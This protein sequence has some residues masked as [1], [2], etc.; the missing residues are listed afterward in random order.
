[1]CQAVDYEHA[2]QVQRS[3]VRVIYMECC[4][5]EHKIEFLEKILKL[6][7]VNEDTYNYMMTILFKHHALHAFDYNVKSEHTTNNVNE[8][9]NG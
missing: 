9:F 3:T 6:K 7:K 8:C 5:Q 2:V 4:K 1:M